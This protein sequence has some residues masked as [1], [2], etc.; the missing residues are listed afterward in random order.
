MNLAASPLR[1]LDDIAQFLEAHAGLHALLLHVESLA[2]PD[3]WIGAGF[4]RNAV[5]D[6]L[7]GYP[8]DPSRLNDV[9]VIYLD[10]AETADGCEDAH[11][12]QLMALAPG[13]PWQV[14]NQARMHLRNGDA[15]YRSTY[16]AIARWPET[17]TAIAARTVSGKVEVIAPYGIGDLISLIVRPTPAFAHKMDVY[18]ERLRS[19]DWALRWPRLTFSETVPKPGS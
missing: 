13:V 3:A 16:E 17:A 10:P 19:K 5:W 18:R 7:H 15:P 1:D 14:R 6:V 4:I 12:H 8:I 11:E 2:L 9:D